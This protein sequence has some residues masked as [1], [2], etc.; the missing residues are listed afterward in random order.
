MVW[1]NNMKLAASLILA[2]AVLLLPDF[3]S[4]L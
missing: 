2:A 1:I 4:A 3:L